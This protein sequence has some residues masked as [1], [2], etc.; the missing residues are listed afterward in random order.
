M[1]SLG[2]HVG[3]VPRVH[4]GVSY[5]ELAVGIGEPVHPITVL[6]HCHP[7]HGREGQS[8]HQQEDEEAVA[9]L[10]QQAVTLERIG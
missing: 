7:K 4:V 3:V 1:W 6:P 9:D 10:F 5:M 2:V 8:C